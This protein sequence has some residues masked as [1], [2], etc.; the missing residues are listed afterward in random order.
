MIESTV[1]LYWASVRDFE[2]CFDELTARLPSNE[3]ERAHRL[4]VTAARQQFVLGR[5]LLRRQLGLLLGVAPAA[6]ELTVAERGKPHLAAPVI[7]LAFNLSHSGDVVALAV[8]KSQ[9]GV[10]VELQRPVNLAERLSRRFF[11]PAESEAVLAATGAVRDRVFLRI[12]TQKE[13][14][15]KATGLGVG[16]PLREV[17]TQPDPTLPPDLLAISGDRDEAARWS[18]TEAEIPGAVCIVALAGPPPDLDLHR[19][20]SLDDL[21]T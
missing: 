19:I 10:D 9:I 18:L 15:L 21:Q 11:S 20:S 3:R 17:E 14:W 12:W 13:A 7:P 6:L 8:A 1:R 16:M 2:D 4:N 5:A